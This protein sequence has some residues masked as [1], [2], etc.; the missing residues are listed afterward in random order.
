M[1][2]KNIYN[3]KK[4]GWTFEGAEKEHII[5]DGRRVDLLHFAMFRS[6]WLKR[7]SQNIET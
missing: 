6:E 5:L 2:I 1:N 3:Y 7:R 4:Q